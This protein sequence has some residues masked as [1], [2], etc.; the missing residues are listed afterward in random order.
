MR[1]FRSI[2]EFVKDDP[3]NAFFLV[4]VVVGFV[5]YIVAIEGLAREMH[6]VHP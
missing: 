1:L 2:V 6:R 5:V 4:I 3:L